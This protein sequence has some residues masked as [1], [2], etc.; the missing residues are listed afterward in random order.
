MPIL[1]E[2][3]V[4]QGT[5]EKVNKR[6]DRQCVSRC[7]RNNYCDHPFAL[8]WPSAQRRMVCRQYSNSW[9]QDNRIRHPWANHISFG[10]MAHG[11]RLSNYWKNCDL[12]SSRHG[13]PYLHSH[14]AIMQRPS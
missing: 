5:R 3:S 10:A 11:S 9:R 6:S 2:D 8:P 4:N 12:A 1:L 14:H 13:R 7:R